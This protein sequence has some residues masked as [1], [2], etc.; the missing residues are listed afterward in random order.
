MS[1]DLLLDGG[2]PIRLL[3]LLANIRFVLIEMLGGASVPPLIVEVLEDSIR[4]DVSNDTICVDDAPLL[5]VS[6]ADEPSVEIISNAEWLTVSMA[7]SRSRMKYL[8][9]AATAIVL[10]RELS[11]SITDDRLF[12]SAGSPTSPESLLN[13]LRLPGGEVDWHVAA[14]KIHLDI[15][16]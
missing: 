4:G 12:F 11:G 7:G 10:A 14:S 5:M 9:G 8:L 2:R 3:P 6:V 1:V 15:I 16:E 13:R